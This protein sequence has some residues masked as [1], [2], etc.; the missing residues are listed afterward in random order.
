MAEMAVMMMVAQGVQA[1][2]GMMQGAAQQKA[3]KDKQRMLEQAAAY[4]AETLRRR[5]NEE[6]AASQRT[7]Q[8]ERDKKDLALSRQTALAAKSGA[9]VENP[10]ILQLLEETDSYGDFL[11]S[12][13]LYRG[14]SRARGLKDQADVG[15]WNAA[16]EG[17]A[18]KK[19]G[20]AA[21]AGSILEGIGMAAETFYDGYK[22]GAFGST[23][24]PDMPDISYDPDQ[25]WMR[26]KRATAGYR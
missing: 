2:G 25:N 22:G 11:A 3:G 26:P 16:V 1:V 5:A 18:A 24:T 21:F 6:S 14:E 8:R 17:R 12:T 13:E 19:A 4:N 7:A 9:G 10:T 20:D 15:M 23:S